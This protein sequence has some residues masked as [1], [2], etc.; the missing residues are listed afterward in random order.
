LAVPASNQ[1]TVL[2]EGGPPV[3]VPSFANL[4]LRQVAMECQRLGFELKVAGTGRA[5]EQNPPAGA[6]VSVGAQLWVRFAR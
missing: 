4:A 5:I 6:E 3:T 1:G 2:L